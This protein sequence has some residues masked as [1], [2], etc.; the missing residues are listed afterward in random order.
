MLYRARQSRRYSDSLVITHPFH[1]LNGQRL[2]V[3]ITVQKRTGLVFVCEV[4]GR[5]RVTVRQEWTD[6]GAPAVPER[7]AADGLAAAR[8][9]VDALAT[10]EAVVHDVAPE[11]VC[12]AEARGQLEQPAGGDGGGEHAGIA[13]ARGGGR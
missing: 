9:L 5:R 4:E 3:L 8:A 12:E 10:G 13:A 11:G 2:A 7:L 1:P 6:R